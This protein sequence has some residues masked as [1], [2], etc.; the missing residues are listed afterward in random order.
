MLQADKIT[1]L[2]CRLSQE[3]M[4]AGESESIQ[5]Q[6]LILQRY[7]DE[8]FFLNTR[9]FV[10]DGFSGVSFE[11]EGL[12]AMLREVEAGNVA[13][14]ITKDLSRLGRNYLKT[15][16]L[17]EIV[18]PEYEVRY[19]AINDGVDTAREDNEFTPLRNW[20][21]EFYARDTSKKIRAVKQAK[22]QRGERVNGE[23]PYGY[24]ADPNDRNHLIP[25][26]ETAHA[27]KQIF[28]MYVRG[29]RIC[30][31]Q[32]WLRDNEILTVGELRYRR[33]GRTQHPRP[34]LNAWYNWPEKTLYDI[35]A[36]QE[37]LGHTIT[38][39]TYKVS[40]K[41]KK[42]RKNAEDKRYFFPNTHEP[43][44][45]EETFELAQK[46]ITTR[47]R[48]TKSDEI[49]LFSG[50][51]FCGDC[52][53]KMY[54]QKGA[55]TPERKHAY[56]CGNYR[57]RARNDFLCTTHYIRKSVLKELVLAD[58]QRIMSY[59]KGHEQEFIQTATEC[60]EQ[61]MKKALGHQRKELDKAEARLGE[62]NLL[63]RKLYEDNALGRLSNE[64]FVFLTSGYE[65]EKRELTKRTAELKKEID[66][67][68]ERSADVKRFVALVRRYTE[69][70]ELTYE[71]VHEFIDRILVYELDKNTN[72]RKIEIFYSFVGK[73]DT[74]DQPTES[75]SYFRQ[76]GAD[77]KSVVV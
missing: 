43:L 66:T 40:Y 70:S 51:L 22:A 64:Q 21:N 47:H 62:I 48:P 53:Y 45:D 3:D 8:H 74:G 31:I 18:F 69:I 71:N 15:G 25:D 5:N 57:N 24:I 36:R 56:T 75:V 52:G 2:Y 44:I 54:L 1:A 55:G 49:D 14:V 68:A 72:T 77:V 23:V 38:A 20:F 67:A 26:P 30:E 32:N 27:V 37:Y 34:Q 73:V 41:S 7:A 65:D 76:I 10:D 50:L 17:I 4:Q 46:R 39:K 63:F 59:V 6:K 16:E 28:A 13:T 19:I 33:T 29:D 61:A 58:L 42:T 9:F 60:S 11:R 35:L 12:Q